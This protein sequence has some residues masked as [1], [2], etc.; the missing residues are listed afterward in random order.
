MFMLLFKGFLMPEQSHFKNNSYAIFKPI[1][2]HLYI[3]ILKMWVKYNNK[4][5]LFLTTTVRCL[6]HF[7]AKHTDH[8][9]PPVVSTL[10]SGKGSI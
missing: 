4:H 2:V 7:A 1:C 6:L 10:L 8:L 5:I 9:L 3:V